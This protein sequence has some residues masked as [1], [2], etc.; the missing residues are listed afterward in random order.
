MKRRRL[1]SATATAIAI[2]ALGL[3]LNGAASA[4]TISA[5][6]YAKHTVVLDCQVTLT[7]GLVVTRWPARTATTT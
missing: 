1:A 2:P 5:G 6:F 4:R 3:G 7:S